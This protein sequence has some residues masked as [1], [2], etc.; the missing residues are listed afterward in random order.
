MVHIKIH[1]KLANCVPVWCFAA[2]SAIIVQYLPSVLKEEVAGGSH[3]ISKQTASHLV[4]KTDPFWERLWSILTSF[5]CFINI[6]WFRKKWSKCSH[7]RKRHEFITWNVR[8]ETHFSVCMLLLLI[9]HFNTAHQSFGVFLTEVTPE[10]TETLYTLMEDRQTILCWRSE[11]NCCLQNK[12][13]FT[14]HIQLKWHP[15]CTEMFA[16]DDLSFVD[17]MN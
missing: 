10:N 7:K 1:N 15:E 12:E 3:L 2:L 4:C 5:T 8:L 13:D 6:Q 14:L 11:K 17:L 16:W 9:R